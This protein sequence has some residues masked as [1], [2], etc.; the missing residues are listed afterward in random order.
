MVAN[1]IVY[2]MNPLG[3]DSY[4]AVFGT[5]TYYHNNSAVLTIDRNDFTAM[6]DDATTALSG[7]TFFYELWKY[8][9]WKL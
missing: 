6:L 1:S 2:I 9:I 8:S 7:I 5:N 3:T 4:K